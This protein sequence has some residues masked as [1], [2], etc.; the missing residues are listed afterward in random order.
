MLPELFARGGPGAAW[1]LKALGFARAPGLWGALAVLVLML[2][3]PPGPLRGQDNLDE[4]AGTFTRLWSEGDL[5]GI[6][7]LFGDGHVSLFLEDRSYVSIPPRN[8]RATLK[9]YLSRRGSGTAT[10]VRTERTGL[11][12]QLGFAQVEWSIPLPGTPEVQRYTVFVELAGTGDGWRVT[13]IRI[14]SPGRD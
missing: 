2:A 13:E 12:P 7:E 8:A 9:D 4:A 6:E 14:L 1:R 3:F 5:G 10:V 11:E